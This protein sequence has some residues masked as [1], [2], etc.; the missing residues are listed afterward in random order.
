MA[1]TARS[2]SAL[3]SL[4]SL[5]AVKTPYDRSGRFDFKALDVLL[6]HHVRAGTEGVIVGGTTGEGHLMSW[7]CH[8]MLIAHC[9]KYFGDSLAIVGNVGSNNTGEAVYASQQGFAVGM[10]AALHINPYYGKTSERGV[11]RH[12]EESLAFGPTYVYNV[13]GRTGQDISPEVMLHFRDHPHLI[14]VKECAGLERIEGY[15]A[16]GIPCW[17][18]NDDDLLTGRAKGVISVASNVIPGIVS[19]LVRGEDV[20]QETRD[21]TADLMRWLFEEPNPIRVNTMLMMMDL[22]EPV[23]RLPYVPSSREDREE[24][25]EILRRIGEENWIGVGARGLRVMDDDEFVCVAMH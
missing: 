4:R 14:G 18:G 25:A 22:C 21:A 10:D 3:R 23:F 15:A 11:I 24:G 13:P 1:S 20:P 8:V 6:E 12:L 5:V 7:P 19:R 2:V 9:A 16:E 17:T